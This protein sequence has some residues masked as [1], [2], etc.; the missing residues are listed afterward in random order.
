MYTCGSGYIRVWDESA[1]QALDTT[2][3]AQLDFQVRGIQAW[4]G[5]QDKAPV[6]SATR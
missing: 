5:N 1:V 2:P 3:L 6:A 4:L